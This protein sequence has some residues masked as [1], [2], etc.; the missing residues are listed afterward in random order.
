MT[1]FVVDESITWVDLD[2]KPGSDPNAIDPFS[3]E[4]IPVAIL[5]TDNFDVGDV[6]V[7]TLAFGPDGASPVRPA[8]REKC[9]TTLPSKAATRS[10]RCRH[11]RP[12]AGTASRSRSCCRPLCGLAD[13]C[14]VAGG[15]GSSI[16]D[17]TRSEDSIH[18]KPA[19][20]LKERRIPDEGCNL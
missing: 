1:P 20:W 18:G 2:I 12:A 17:R 13:G 15:S 7:A 8:S 14:G 6:D 10:R 16:S 19:R 9:S 3:Q 5:G 11:R 4:V